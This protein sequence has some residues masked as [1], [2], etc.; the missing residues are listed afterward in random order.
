MSI[1]IMNN[2]EDLPSMLTIDELKDYLRISRSTAY[3]LT[4]KKGFPTVR[5]GNRILVPR[6]KFIEWLNQHTKIKQ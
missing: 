4:N 6:D 2:I 3:N 1:S 5:I